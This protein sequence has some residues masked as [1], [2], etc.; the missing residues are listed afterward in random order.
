MTAN[1]KAETD[2]AQANSGSVGSNFS[3]TGHKQATDVNTEEHISVVSGIGAATAQ[4]R[5]DA[6]AANKK[7]TYDQYQTVD[8]E[9]ILQNRAHIARV[10]TMAEVHLAN[11]IDSSNAQ[12]K[13]ANN[14]FNL[15]GDRMWNIN[16]TDGMAVLL[17]E[18]VGKRVDDE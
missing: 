12:N 9:G 4:D 14:L 3:E 5:A 13:A 11:L 1:S 17:A 7:R 10:Q 18:T 16:E 6:W 8:V 15:A 2:A